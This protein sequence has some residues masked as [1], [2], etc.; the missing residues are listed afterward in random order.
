M[1]TTRDSLYSFEIT[2]RGM[3]SSAPGWWELGRHAE[4]G[5]LLVWHEEHRNCEELPKIE[6]KIFGNM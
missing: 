1:I 5:D 2:Q 6:C 3:K 4:V